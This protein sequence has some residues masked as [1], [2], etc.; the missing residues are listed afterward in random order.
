MVP[1]RTRLLSL[2]LLL[3]TTSAAAAPAAERPRV[4]LADVERGSQYQELPLNGTVVALRNAEV[5]VAVAGLVV[6]RSVDAGD[7]VARGDVLLQLDDELAR[8]SLRSAQAETLEAE[9]RAREARRQ[10]D[11]ARSVGAG[12]NIAASEVRRL[13][14]QAETAQAVL[15][16][17]R[18]A[19][20][21]A[22][23]RLERHR[24]LA[25]FDG[26]ISARAVDAGQW[27]TPGDAVF[28]L[29]DT[30]AVRLDF[31]VPQQVLAGLRADADAELRVRDHGGSEQQARILTWLPVTGGTARTFTLQAAPP[32]DLPVTPGMAVEAT[33]RLGTGS[34]ALSI[35]RDALNRYPEGRVTVW[36]AE[37]ADGDGVYRVREQRIRVAGSS[38]ERIYVAEGLDGS[39]R[40]VARGNE[41]LR[42]ATEVQLAGGEQR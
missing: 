15:A 12:R 21:L 10:L 31:Q 28:T 35:P 17:I 27:V 29:V 24:L 32:D 34:M 37:P 40:V 13:E 8:L 41:S 2:V 19:A 16:R 38:G 33:L 39:E 25:P 6:A 26:I 14:S 11:E 18:S 1:E 30:D 7:R 42:D 22:R 20:A 4:E 3:C 9:S 23:A 36:I 5:S